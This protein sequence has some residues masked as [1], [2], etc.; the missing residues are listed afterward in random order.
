MT[1]GA[2]K[3]ALIV[4]WMLVWVYATERQFRPRYRE[5]I[6]A[7]RIH[8]PRTWNELGRPDGSVWGSAHAYGPGTVFNRY[9]GRRQYLAV[10]APDLT[11][12]AEALRRWGRRWSL[13]ALLIWMAGLE[14]IDRVFP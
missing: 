4:F 10:E 7:L 1:S 2:L 6:R 12:A 14:V 8:D 3:I 11:Q 9:L 13:A 5:F